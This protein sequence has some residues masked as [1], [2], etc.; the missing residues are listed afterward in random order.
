MWKVTVFFVALFTSVL[1]APGTT[2]DTYISVN[3]F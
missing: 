1:L 3:V 2:F